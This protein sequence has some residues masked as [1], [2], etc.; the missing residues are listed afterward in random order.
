MK[1]NR[2]PENVVFNIAGREYKKFIYNNIA[3]LLVIAITDSALFRYK[4][5]DNL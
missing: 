2:D 4:T 1:N 3:F 5:L